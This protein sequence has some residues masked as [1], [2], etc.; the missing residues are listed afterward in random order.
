MALSNASNCKVATHFDDIG[1]VPKLSAGKRD[2]INVPI[3]TQEVGI[4]W[5]A[6]CIP[7][8]RTHSG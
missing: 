5:I 7:L 3:S 8:G 6:V 2:K 4:G 1:R